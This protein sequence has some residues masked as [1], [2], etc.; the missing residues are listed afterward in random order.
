MAVELLLGK[1]KDNT[2]KDFL[3]SAHGKFADYHNDNELNVLVV[4]LGDVHMIQEWW[5]Y[6][7][8]HEG[9]LTHKPF[10]A[11]DTF[12]RVDVIIY[13]NLLHR[14]MNYKSIK[15][16]AWLMNDS[17]NLFLS[18]QFR[19]GPKNDVHRFLIPH[20][21][22]YTERIRQYH[23][24]GNAPQDLLESLK[25]ASFVVYELEENQG[26]MLF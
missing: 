17:F 2:M 6:L 1:N 23:V 5:H 19:Q 8:N 9:L 25:V 12:S 24:P 11:H 14:H 21:P 18:N 20:I 7:H 10:I 3:Q 16:S 26:I 22:N 13:T 4:S 15:G